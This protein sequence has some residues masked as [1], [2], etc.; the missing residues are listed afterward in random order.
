MV[1]SFR[2]LSFAVFAWF[3]AGGTAAVFAQANTPPTTTGL[4]NVNATE[5]GTPAVV[6][7]WAAFSDAQ[8]A[9]RNLKFTVV[10]NTN[11]ALVSPQVNTLN[12]TLTLTFRLNQNGTSNL[13]VRCTD[14]GGLMV[15][16]AF[17]V[18]VAAVPDAPVLPTILP[19]RVKVGL[20]AF[21]RVTATDGDLP[22]DLLVYSLD[23]ASLGRGMTI[24]PNN[25]TISWTPNISH[26]GQGF[27]SV[28][29]VTD[30]GNR[31]ATRNFTVLVGN[32]AFTT[33]PPLLAVNDRTTIPLNAT[34]NLSTLILTNDVTQGRAVRIVQLRFPL[35]VSGSETLAFSTTNGNITLNYT[36]RGYRGPRVVNYTL[37]D[38]QGKTDSGWLVFTTGGYVAPSQP[39]VPT[40]VTNFTLRVGTP[41]GTVLGSV[42]APDPDGGSRIF[43]EADMNR[44]P[45]LK[46]NVGD[47]V[48]QTVSGAGTLQPGEGLAPLSIDPTTGA[49]RFVGG[50]GLQA[51]Q[52]FVR[53]YMVYDGRTGSPNAND[54]NPNFGKIVVT[55]IP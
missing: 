23:A 41:V 5:D 17:T 6:N 26:V 54:F 9:D 39:A 15:Q 29:T 43:T 20:T 24:N 46:T 32:P 10:T 21:F 53:N 51:G 52:V 47:A 34:T 55:V 11:P 45:Q 16:T 12:G 13:T 22:N 36:N 14:A 30:N 27:T 50:I 3:V 1:R 49:I 28:L 8:T 48:V 7:L 40:P 44:F 31:Q 42:S 38:D 25:G 18:T 35:T 4:P 33:A 37:Q 2:R 19:Q